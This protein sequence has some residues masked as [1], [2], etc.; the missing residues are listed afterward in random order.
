MTDAFFKQPILNSPYECPGRHWEL[1]GKG[2]PTQKIIE[3]RRRADLITPIP[4]PKKRKGSKQ[5]ALVFDEG[6]GLSTEQQ[7]FDHTAV[8]NA[9][10]DEVDRWRQLP[11]SADWRVTAETARLLRHW[12]DH[13]FNDIRPFFCQ[14]EA[15]ETVIWLTEVAPQ[16]GKSGQRFLE[17]L[18]DANNDANPELMRLAVKLA[19]GAGKTTVMAMLIAWQT[20]NAVR[21]PQSKRFTRGFLVV[22]PGLTIKDR[23]RVLQP[24]DPDSYY[25]SRELVPGDLLEDIKRARIVITNYHAFKLR[26]RLQLSKGGRSL[27]QGRGDALQTLETEGQMLQR[28]MPELMG[29]KNILVLNDEAHHCY[30]EKPGSTDVDDLKGDDRKAA[31]ENNEAARLWISG[32]EAVNRKIGLNRAIDLSATPFFLRGSGY[33][34]G[35]LFPWTMSDF[36]L[37]DAIEC[38]IVK[39]PRVPIADNIPGGDMPMFRDLWNNIRADMPK[40][41]RSKAKD[42]NPL[43]LPP[44]LQTALQALYGHYEKTFE[45]W[46]IEK[47][48]VPPCFIVVC[49][50]TSASKLVYDYISGFER[51]LDD[52][53]RRIEL[54]RLPL[55][56]NHDENGNP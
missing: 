5:A 35:T 46:Q 11:N 6:K 34:E 49:Q 27:L 21:H 54:G 19:T 43:D 9:V 38:G 53:T 32:L 15:A 25:A 1:D 52:G 17:H 2:Q 23:L 30:R 39:L 48:D 33:P 4:K 40:K 3:S 42:L 28:V 36:S 44:P 56:R 10:R 47:V 16:I 18:A 41:R 14:V 37:M 12:R 31:Q 26:E 22:A 45:L 24:N 51:S 13:P 8:V 7:Q 29:M 55:F 20:I 50:N